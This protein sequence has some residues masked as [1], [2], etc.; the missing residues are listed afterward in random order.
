MI[1]HD[2]TL[3][4]TT[5]GRGAVADI[6][7]ENL[8]TLNAGRGETVPTL[9]EVLDRFP[10]T[11]LILEIKDAKASTAVKQVL[12]RHRAE[13]RVLIGGFEHA[14]VAPFGAGWLRSASSREVALFWIAARMGARSVSGGYV[15]FTVPERHRRLRVVD[16]KFMLLAARMQKPVH[17][18]TVNDV[19]Q[20]GRLRSI[21]VCGMITN[22]PAR[23]RE[24]S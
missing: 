22:F 18:W 7:F 10:E 13:G 1:L 9:S 15:A 14:A 2:E 17:V 21:G 20:A 6:R 12:T 5:N 16:R 11:P 24:V 19:S 4:R 23:L 8:R 3:D